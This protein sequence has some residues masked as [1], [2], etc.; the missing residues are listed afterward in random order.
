MNLT[1]TDFGSSMRRENCDSC[2]KPTKGV[3][4][5]SMFNQEVICID[6]KKAEKGEANYKEAVDADHKAIKNGDYNSPGIGRG[7]KSQPH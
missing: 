4:I 3:T 1:N 2:H 5:M 7:M 6:C